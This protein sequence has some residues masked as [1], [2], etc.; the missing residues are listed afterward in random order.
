MQP[1]IGLEVHVQLK[2]NTKLFCGC[3]TEFGSPPNS[4]ICPVCTGQPGVLPVLNKKAIELS[5]KASLALNCKINN[6]SIF[7]RK[8]YF[9]PDLPKNYQIS[10]YEFPLAENGFIM[11]SDKDNNQ[12]KIRIKRVHLEEDAG[13]LLHTIGSEKL[14]CSLV[15][16]NRTGIPLLEIVSQPDI[17]SP[18]E[19]YDYLIVLKQILQYIDVSDCDMEKG[20]LRCDVNISILQDGK[21]GI[22]TEL[23]NMNSFKAIKE[24]LEYEISRQI[25]LINSGKKIVQQTL[26]WNP[27][28]GITEVMRTKE[29]AHDYRYFP[30]PDLLPLEI[31]DTF[32]ENIKKDIP[33]LPYNRKHRLMKD[34]GLNEYDAG[35]ITSDKKLADYYE[36]TIE[37]LK[38]EIS[39]QQ[40]KE[41]SKLVSNWLTTELLGRLNDKN[42]T[43][44]DSPVSFQNLAKLILLIKKTII[45]TKI[46]KTVFDEMFSSSKDPELIIKEKGLVQIT[47]QSLIEN[48][49]QD[50]LKENQKIIQDYKSGK[51]KALGAIIGAVMKKT[52]GKANPKLVNEKL[53]QILNDNK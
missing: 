49:I 35:V 22:K 50:V 18:L 53:K 21:L 52:H 44:D 10:Q 29:E 38:K 16:F 13:K 27:D 7:A 42:K 19:A 32:I 24:A 43:I 8:N 5:L 31:D 9:Y 23:K 33:E 36:N 11:I 51:E 6:K 2:T 26:L 17:N 47:D 39:Q 3:S 46:A 25:T 30:E 15:D 41:Y 1:K 34:Y 14:D 20:M 37:I 4:N 48:I 12:K 28:K 45:S 40:L